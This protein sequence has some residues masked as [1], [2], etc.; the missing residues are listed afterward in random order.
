MAAAM[1]FQVVNARAA[2]GKWNTNAS[3]NWSTAA[4]W[5]PAVVPGTTAGDVVRLTF[6]I[7]G[8]RTVTMNTTSRTVG[9]LNIG[10]SG[11]SYRAY[12]LTN[13]GGARL[14]FDNSGS[15]ASLVQA[16]TTASD[17]IALPITLADNLNISNRS[18]LT[19]SGVIG[20]GGAGKSITAT[21]A[22]YLILS[23]TNTFSGGVT[24]SNGTVTMGSSNALGTGALTMNGGILS[25]SGYSA[26]MGALIIQGSSTIA[27]GNNQTGT[28]AFASGS[29]TA[30]TLTISNW[31]GTAG[32][33]GTANR[34]F[35]TAAPNATFL[36]NISFD[37]YLPGAI[38]L[39]T[40]EIVPSNLPTKLAITSVNGG[41]APAIN[42]AFSVVVQ[43]QDAGGTARTV[44]ANTAVSLSLNAG[45]GTLGGTLTG[46]ITAGTSSVTISGVT[47]S[48]AENG[49][50]LTATRTSGD[51]L[52]AA[53]SSAFTVSGWYN[54]SWTKRIAIAIDHTK[55]S[56]PLTNF[57][58]LIN[59]TNASLQA[60]AQSSGN[61]L[62]F[63]SDDGTTKLAHE[64]ESYTNSNGALVAWVNVPLL[65][66][67]VDTTLYLYYGNSGSA[68]Q[69]NAAGVWDAN[70][71]GVWHLKEDPTGTAPQMKDSTTNSN[72]GTAKGSPVSGDQQSGK[73]NG[74]LR[75]NGTN[76]WV[77]CGNASSLQITGALTIE[78]WTKPAVT[79]SYMGIV[80][81]ASDTNANYKGFAL[82]KFNT[83]DKFRFQN[84]NSGSTATIDSD[85]GY[86]DTNWHHV[87][88]VHSA[89]NVLTLYVD[90][91]AQIATTNF[92]ITDSALAFHIGRQYVAYAQR[93]WNGIIDEVRVSNTNRSAAWIA[94]EYNNQSSPA[95]F[96]SLG[97]QENPP[98]TQL[99]ITSVNGGSSPTVGAGFNV[100][101]QSQGA[102]GTPQNVTA[103]TAV[104][105]SVNTGSGTLGGTLTGT[106]LN[107]TSSV[108]ISG[109]TYSKAENGVILTATRTSGLSLTAG[110]SSSFNVSKA[111]VTVSSGLLANNKVYDGTTAATISSNNVVLSGVIAGDTANVKLSTNGYTATFASV[112]VGSGKTVTVSGLTLTGSASSNYSL[113]QPSLIA[114]I[115]AAT[116]TITSG[117]TA[118]NKVYDG[119]TAATI[120]SNNVVLSG[121]IA[122]DTANVKL[123]TNGYTA[124]FASATAGSGIGVTVS[125]LSLTGTASGNYA[126]TQPAGL[127]ATITAASTTLAL[128]SSALT[129]AHLASLTFTATVQAGGVTATGAGGTVQ[130]VTNTVNFGGAVGLTS[131]AVNTNLATLPRGTNLV[132]AVYSGDG[133]Y[134]GSTSST[135]NEVV[136]NNPP[137]A[138]V[139]NV[140]RTAGLALLIL[141]ADLTNSWSDVDGDPVTLSGI[142]LVTTNGVT[143]RTNNVLI[144]YTNSLNVN[145]KILY[146]IT[147]GQG[148]TNLGSINITV[149]AFVTGQ[150]TGTLTVSNGSITATFFG[151]PTYVYEVQRSTN[152]TTG[153]GWVNI[154]TNTVGS[155]GQ[156]NITDHFTDLGGNIP[157]AAFYRL[158]WHP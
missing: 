44:T 132:Y 28:L 26:T 19:L 157:S 22:G 3:G 118:N 107:G 144:L 134:A 152:L 90:G 88:G 63:T 40:G 120:S 75:F 57:P 24:I 55:V 25:S 154:S 46:T 130:F 97:S 37:G 74:A 65:S 10:D 98:P 146:G 73:I 93:F 138:A 158:G 27:L 70:F 105:L 62:L 41:I 32:V 56:G 33:S 15:G 29:Y 126:L 20:D 17:V 149:T 60:S 137:V 81:K 64:I 23:A 86:A 139:F 14:T 53:N 11:S 38:R 95:A 77:D 58:V 147:D 151:I 115:T 102:G 59:L 124:T 143:V 117:I 42:T 113:T 45:S 128:T 110:N 141:R 135:L 69:Q 111:V 39:G 2:S 50:I 67:T 103:D 49:V 61:D 106:I 129:N 156:F 100:V 66:S 109:V 48:K 136:T 91:V 8:A 89:G 101:V 30:G 155:H 145:D 121:V 80:G 78:A 4:N 125:G 35:I 79:G 84:F 96:Y 122:G 131:G 85:S 82:S 16:I 153:I 71:K 142:N 76:D 12:T 72:H 52:T 133:N 34:I 140:S 83:G 21:G 51:T 114:N 108:T 43:A 116:V 9:T 87:V 13:S 148:G 54:A 112:A 36:A 92:A 150:S 68:N 6:N 104:S 18:T 1:F 94:T 31:T 5:T 127:T 7:T 123:S 119:T 99:A 47:Y